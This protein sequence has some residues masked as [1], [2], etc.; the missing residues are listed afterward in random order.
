VEIQGVENK[1]ARG[2][3]INCKGIAGA[4]QRDRVTVNLI[5]CMY[6]RICA[7]T[8]QCQIYCLLLPFH[9][10]ACIHAF[11]YINIYII[12]IYTYIYICIY[13]YV[14][15]DVSETVYTQCGRQR[16]HPSGS[17]A[18]VFR[19]GPCVLYLMTV[20]Y[21]S[22]VPPMSKHNITSPVCV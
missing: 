8:L 6:V 11:T 3:I 12:Y 7:E 21:I 4:C 22:E 17:T 19:L 13:I 18:I 20:K 10:C 14:Y 9:A 16:I 2:G 1:R 15:L 5:I